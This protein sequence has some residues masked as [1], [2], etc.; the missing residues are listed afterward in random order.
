VNGPPAARYPGRKPRVLCVDDE[1]RIFQAMQRQLASEFEVVG[2]DNALEALTWLAEGSFQVIVSDMRM[3]G[4]NGTALLSRAREAQ[5]DTV[6]VLLTGEADIADAINVVN[7][8]NIFRFL[9]KPCPP[10]VLR[11]ALH[12]AAELHRTLTAERELLEKTLRGAVEAL[13][14]IL[15][16]AN[17]A[18]FARAARIQATVKELL[19]AVAPA[20]QWSIEVAA[21]LS[22]VGAVVLAPGT[23]QKLNAGLALTAEEARQMEML[24]SHAEDLLKAIPRLEGVREMIRDQAVA[25]SKATSRGAPQAGSGVSGAQ[26]LRLAVGLEALEAAGLQRLDALRTLGSKEGSYDPSLIAALEARTKPVYDEPGVRAITAQQLRPGMTIARDVTDRAGRMLV[27][28]GYE[29]TESLI[30]RIRNWGT[31]AEIEEPILV[32]ANKDLVDGL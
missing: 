11:A 21:M 18:A 20:E 6:R 4:M 12:A 16:L 30:Q 23:V 26:M 15:S 25:Y 27:G 24:P 31:G 10:D 3:P 5:P 8:G 28:R 2:T 19:A 13:L 29:V 14:G 9:V 7:Q 17:P 1:P 22:Q 32:V